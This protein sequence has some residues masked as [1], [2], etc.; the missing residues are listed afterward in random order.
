MLAQALE[1]HS[2][3]RR[4]HTHGKGLAREQHLDEASAEEHLHHLL[5]DRQQPCM[6]MHGIRNEK[7]R[8]YYTFRRQF[9]EKPSIIPG[10][11][12]MHGIT[13][14]GSGKAV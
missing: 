3:G 11:S 4:I 7:E 10:C 5:H 9:D 12:G 2:P 14:G 8:K 13:A 1:D 6:A